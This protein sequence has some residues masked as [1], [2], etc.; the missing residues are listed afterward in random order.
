MTAGQCF[1]ISL[2]TDLCIDSSLLGPDSY[3]QFWVKCNNVMCCNVY[4]CTQV[5]INNITATINV[6]Q[7][8]NIEI[9]N[10]AASCTSS[11]VNGIRSATCIA[12]VAGI[13]GS[14]VIGTTCCCTCSY[15][16]GNPPTTTTTTTT[17]LPPMTTTTT[18]T[19]SGPFTG[20]YINLTLDTC[21]GD[22]EPGLTPG[23]CFYLTVDW[24]VGKGAGKGSAGVCFICNGDTLTYRCVIGGTSS[25]SASGTWGPAII[26]QGD[27]VTLVTRALE[28]GGESFPYAVACLSSIVPIVGCYC[29]CPGVNGVSSGAIA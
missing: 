12:N 25:N 20:E 13:S 9:F 1:N 18:T 22:M 29:V 17:T 8:D 10:E 3:N 11:S 19:T 4:N 21:E 24:A 14:F 6:K 5:C 7:G 23:S 15:T 28:I 26:C 27:T 2:S 16:N